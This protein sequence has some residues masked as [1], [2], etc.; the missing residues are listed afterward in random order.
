[1]IV[2]RE[3]T[4][5][6]KKIIQVLWAIEATAGIMSINPSKKARR[7]LEKIAEELGANAIISYTIKKDFLDTGALATGTAVIVG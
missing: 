4:I 3:A 5:P 6:N 2:V 1:M 7:K